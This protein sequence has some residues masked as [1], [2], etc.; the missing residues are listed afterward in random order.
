MITSKVKLFADDMKLWHVVRSKKD[1]NVI[2][3]DLKT[4]EKYSEKWLLK[5]NAVK[6][7]QMSIGHNFDTKYSMTHEAELKEIEI[8]N[9]SRDLGIQVTDDLKW[10]MQCNQAASKA[11]S[12]LGMI[13]R[14]FGNVSKEIFT[15]L[16]ST[17]VRPNLEYCVQAWA[18]YYQKDIDT[19][20]K[21][22]RRA[23]KLVKN[24]RHLSYEERLKKLQLY[25]LVRRKKR[26][27]LIEV[28]K[29]LNKLEDTD[30]EIFFERSST[31]SLRGH[32][33]KLFKSFSKKLCRKNFF[34]QR[35]INDWNSL[36]QH[37]IDSNSLNVFKNRL[38][39]VMDKDDRTD[40]GNK[41]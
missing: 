29:I 32:S 12:V 28:F 9:H 18:P 8:V 26:G 27:D 40:M 17:Y 30:E 16:Y 34:S 3:Q 6:C 21:V 14:T 19:L 24:I 39:L 15:S 41:S 7:Q 35:V 5:F 31:M 25:S 33:L 1:E 36:P 38:D 11:M 10:S 22:Q 37:V 20:E 23:T 2:S 13:K 4:L